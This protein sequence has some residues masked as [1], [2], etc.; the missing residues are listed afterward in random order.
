VKPQGCCRLKK[1]HYTLA[2]IGFGLYLIWRTASYYGRRYR[3]AILI[4]LVPVFLL[5]LKLTVFPAYSAA[6]TGSDSTRTVFVP[7]GSSLR[8]IAGI[9]Q[10]SGVLQHKELFI[11]LGQVS[12]Y[13][14]QLKAGLFKIPANMPAWHL[15]KYLRNP[16]Y[17]DV[18]VTFPEGMEAPEYASILHRDL[19]VDSAAFMKL[20][21]DT[22]FCRSLGV[23]A[24]NLEG[25]LLPETYFFT[26]GTAPEEI[27]RLLV[28]N[29]LAIFKPDSIREQMAALDM[30]RN[31]ILTLASIVEGEVVVDSERALVSSVYHNRLDRGW[32]L[33]ADPTIQ[34]ILPGPPRR[35]LL[36][37]LEINSPYNTYL[38]RGLPPGPINNPGKRSILAALYPMATHYMYFV[39]TGDGGHHF[40]R[41]AAEHARWKSQFDKVRK[42]VRRNGRR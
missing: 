38:H 40:S 5:V 24:N 1:I 11:M 13:Q 22:A 19:E 7:H 37:D 14:N 8:E 16:D 23:D 29:T 4:A 39:A 32:P 18:R 34:F 2:Q 35:L 26:Y 33:Q 27:I 21:Y 20:V 42:E 36:K 12:G 25:Y 30:T 10:D 15:L 41:T 17:A 6:E 28:S 9:M 3:S 31:Q